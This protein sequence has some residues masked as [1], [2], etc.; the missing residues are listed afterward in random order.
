MS[1]DG[2]AVG[3]AATGTQQ[4]SRL[5]SG[6]LTLPNCI[7][8][9]AAVMAP[10]IAVIL[11]APAAAAH[12]QGALPL[13]FL[14]AFVGTGF[15]ANTVV[16]FARR[17]PSSG[18]FYN[19]C[20]HA[21]GGGAGFYTGWLYF[22]AYIL[23][24]I[25]L[26]TANGAYLHNYLLTQF[27]VGIAWWILSIALMSLVFVLSL[28]SIKASV[29]VDLTLLGFEILV[30]SVLAV[31]AIAKGGDGNTLHYFSP[32]AS[33]DGVSG[34]GLGAV[35]GILSFI[36]FESAAVLGEET[37]NPRRAIPTAVIGATFII[38]VFY[39]FQMY[40][41]SAGSHLNDPAQLKTFIAD[42]T[43]F[44]TLAHRYANWMTNIIDIAGVLG[45]FSCFLAVQNATVRVIFSMGRDKVLPGA[46]GAVHQRFHSPYV[47]IYALTGLSIAAGLGLSA[48]LGDGLTDVYGWTG[49][50]GTVA[51]VL[52]YM[53][54]NVGLIKFFWRDP[55][56]SIFKHVVA[57]ILGIAC[58]AY[59]LYST[60]KPGQSYPYNL[61]FWI[62]LGWLV[63]GLVAYYVLRTRA[64]EKL[65]AV[66]RVLAADEEELA[67][68]RLASDPAAPISIP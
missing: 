23:L 8:L 25:G 15:V 35:F 40:A 53:L 10:V 30:F 26:F 20:S 43:P 68:S 42:P 21:L 64:P 5:Q 32:H 56:R 41:L 44:P 6:H 1:V 62:V 47:A 60:A 67:E 11:N 16:Q 54:A 63:L 61:V 66:G 3:R 29:R 50:I 51:I 45:L 12:S 52:V 55:E 22:A 46:L 2:S 34:V 59:P 13:S 58:F 27:S 39:V 9:S 24:A 38:G 33:T 37:R 17:L 48:W 57:P 49:S 14:V 31:I 65:A 7:A 18:L 4:P 36:G 19:Y 28:R